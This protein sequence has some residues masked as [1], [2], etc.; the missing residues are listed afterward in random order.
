MTRTYNSWRHMRERCHNEHCRQFRYY[1]GRGITICA[2]W[3]SFENF[4]ADMGERPEGTSLDRI[5]ND[6]NYEPNNCRWATQTQQT[7]NSRRA[8]NI[9]FRGVTRCIGEW[10]EHLGLTR[11]AIQLRLK[12]GWSLDKALS[13]PKVRA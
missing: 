7:K 11:N 5:N 10:G 12:S 2:R 9:T 4:L 6:G 8:R 13:T 1:G 3:G